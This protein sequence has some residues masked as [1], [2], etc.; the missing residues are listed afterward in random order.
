MPEIEAGDDLASLIAD[1]AERQDVPVEQGD[2]LVVTQKIVSKAEGRV[3]HVDEIDPSP[4]AIQL[5]EGHN[6]DPRHTEVIL[7]ESVRIVRMDRGNII[8]E[9]RHGFNCANAGVDAS[10]VPG[11]G[12]LALLPIDPDASAEGIRA[13]I[14][15]RLGKDVAVIISD[16]F[17][18]PWREGAVNVAIGVAGMSPLQD[19][20]GK[21]DA[22]GQM[23]KSTVIALAD[24]LAATAELVMGKVTGVPIAL[25]RGCQYE[26]ADASVQPKGARALVRVPER[27]MFR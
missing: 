5:S 1:A 27:D 24:E 23:M 3:V 2:V 11:E 20:R 16:T 15:E 4:L 14:K 25:I 10:N 7:Q 13:Y 22:Y 26:L 21:E 9:T 17:G 8:S 6:R 12:T 18:R 19:Y